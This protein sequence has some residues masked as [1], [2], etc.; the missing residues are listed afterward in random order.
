MMRIIK[1]FICF[2]ILFS[3]FF[4][5]DS[6]AS[7]SPN[8][9]GT[10]ISTILFILVSGLA[11]YVVGTAKAFREEKQR[12]YG[13]IIPPILKMAYHPE[14]SE[15]EKEFS[16]ALSKLWLYGSKDAARKMNRAVSILHDPQKGDITKAF[17]EAIAEMR[18][19]IQ[20][21]PWKKLDASEV[22][23]FYTRIIG[24]DKI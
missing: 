4:V 21:L 20:L 18:K 23:H 3:I 6:S 8:E 5:Q 14:T 15:D 19:D 9:G 12:V 17:Q 1:K 7:S 11:G 10:F 2:L 13:E 16:K 24:K 22:N